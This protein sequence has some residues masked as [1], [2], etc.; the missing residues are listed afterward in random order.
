MST[1]KFRNPETGEYE[2]VGIPSRPVKTFNGRQGDVVPQAGDYTAEMVGAAPAVEST[3]YPGCYY[4]MVG[5]VK[6]WLNPPALV[7][8]EFRTTERY[9]GK[10]VYVRLNSGI[11]FP[12]NT[13]QSVA[14]LWDY[15]RI[16]ELHGFNTE[17]GAYFPTDNFNG[18]AGQKVDICTYNGGY[19]I[20]IYTNFNASSNKTNYVLA[21]YYK[22]TD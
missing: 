6:E 2:K 4:R 12:S 21:K 17:T 1:I 19:H 18:N 14:L 9:N 13:Y 20:R 15:C 7:G 10:P 5:D 8:E 16:I 11:A 3:E 22:T